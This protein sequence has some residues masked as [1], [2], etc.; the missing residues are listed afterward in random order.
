VTAAEIASLI[1]G[2]LALAVS[3]FL[4]V[5]RFLEWR[6]EARL[7]MDGDWMQATGEHTVL[8]LV[9]TNAGRARGGVR[10]IVLSPSDRY[11]P[12]P[13]SEGEGFIPYDLIGELPAMVDPGHFAAFRI[14]LDP[15]AQ[16]TFTRRL[17]DGGLTHVILIDHKQEP[18]A[19]PTPL[20][21]EA[22]GTRRS[23]YGRVAKR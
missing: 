17:L 6:A 2:T 18:H 11:D 4:A 8:R 10:A 20:R 12:S 22:T 5:L 21:T 1:I 15:T 9:V 3:G 16:N 7:E 23:T 19:F 13:G 14:K